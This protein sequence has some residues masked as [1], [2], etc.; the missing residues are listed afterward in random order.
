MGLLGLLGLLRWCRTRVSLHHLAQQ[1]SGG[2][3]LG[4]DG[5]VQLHEFESKHARKYLANGNCEIIAME[6]LERC[7]QFRSWGVKLAPPSAVRYQSV[8]I[9]SKHQTLVSLSNR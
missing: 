1:K 4:V 3:V 9:P 8:E 2:I 7:R 5:N 6:V